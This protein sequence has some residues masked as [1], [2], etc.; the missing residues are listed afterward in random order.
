MKI[1]VQ[2]DITNEI[3]EFTHSIDCWTSPA[4]ELEY[5]YKADRRDMTRVLEL[6]KKGKIKEARC[7]AD[8]LDTCV[9]YN[10]PKS[11]WKLLKRFTK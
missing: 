9:R 3:N 2:V 8:C 7:M 4:Y 1:N 6:I 10:I 5:A 11:V